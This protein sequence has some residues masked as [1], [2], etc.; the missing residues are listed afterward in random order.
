MG[1]GV[2]LNGY[3]KTRAHRV[4]KANRPFRKDSWSRPPEK[5]LAARKNEESPF[6]PI[7]CTLLLHPPSW[8]SHVPVS[9]LSSGLERS[10]MS[11]RNIR[12]R[13][14]V[15]YPEMYLNRQRVTRKLAHGNWR[16]WNDIFKTYWLSFRS[17]IQSSCRH[18]Q[19]F[20]LYALKLLRTEITAL[21][22]VYIKISILEL[23]DFYV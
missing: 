20:T 5:C 11:I 17:E 4:S 8:I 19:Y 9:F 23:S 13:S 6:Y 15:F 21:F 1:L 12:E 7:F 14:C 10:Y 22:N 2:G 3:E 16:S 18:K